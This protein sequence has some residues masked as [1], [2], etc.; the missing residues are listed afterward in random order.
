MIIY[1]KKMI[2]LYR[3]LILI[4]LFVLAKLLLLSNRIVNRKNSNLLLLAKKE[5]NINDVNNNNGI[6]VAKNRNK[7][8]SISLPTFDLSRRLLLKYLDNTEL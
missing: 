4:C 2:K 3:I 6:K 8:T 5:L 1:C 7:S